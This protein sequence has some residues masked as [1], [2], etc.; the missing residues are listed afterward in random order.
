MF[1]CEGGCSTKRK[2]EFPKVNVAISKNG[3]RNIR[4][5]G[6]LIILSTVVYANP[7]SPRIFA[8]SIQ[9]FPTKVMGEPTEMDKLSSKPNLYSVQK[10]I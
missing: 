9:N 6:H 5:I 3:E 1:A 10:K 7:T 4:L 8:N 2:E